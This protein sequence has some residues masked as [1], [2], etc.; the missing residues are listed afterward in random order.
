MISYAADSSH[1]FL[2]VS[3]GS[4]SHDFHVS[5][6]HAFLFGPICSDVLH[7]YVLFSQTAT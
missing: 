7:R 3:H 6:K 1:P 5:D 2:L 4:A